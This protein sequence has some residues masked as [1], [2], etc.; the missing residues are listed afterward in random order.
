MN[1]IIL[2]LPPAFAGVTHILVESSILASVL[3]VGHYLKNSTVK[4]TDFDVNAYFPSSFFKTN[5]P[6]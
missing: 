5:F 2:S 1:E 3:K 4:V 6:I